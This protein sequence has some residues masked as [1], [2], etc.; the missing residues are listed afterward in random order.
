MGAAITTSNPADFENRQQTYFQRQLLKSLMFNL[1]LA[2][3][4]TAKEIPANSAAYTTRF[5]RPRRAV[6]GNGTTG[7]RI[8]AEGV[9]PT[10]NTTVAVGY[11]D[12]TL[13]Q[14]G[15]LT[16]IS[17]IVRAVDLFDTLSLYSS[18][19]GEDAAL[20]YDSVCSHAIIS[21][22]G[23]ADADGAPNPIPVGQT[24]LYDTTA[25]AVATGRP[26]LGQFERWAGVDTSAVTTS[27]TRWDALAAA[28]NSNSKLTRAVHIGA[29]TRLRGVGGVPGV[30]MINGKYKVFVPSEVMGDLRQD[31]VWLASAQFNNNKAAGSLDQW[32]DFTLDG[33]DFIEAG[34]PFIEAPVANGGG[35][36]GVYGPATDSIANNI[37]SCL[38]VGADA[39]G[40]PKLSGSRAGSNPAAPSLIVLGNADK[41]DP[42]NQMTTLGWKAFYQAILLFTNEATDLPHVL[43][44]RVKT[45]FQG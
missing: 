25:Q 38:Y 9:A 20:D 35:G 14:R 12:V 22:A 42:L 40:V 34:N 21:K 33:G 11:V 7:P 26:A 43:V 6:K 8:L 27:P 1:K 28:T 16:S 41:T 24:T 4:G 19:M 10:A 31:S 29:I 2:R 13:R 37:Y 30:P 44:Q 15:D 32:V 23:T 17:D 18:K 45:T 5:F 3:Y 36:Y 39:F